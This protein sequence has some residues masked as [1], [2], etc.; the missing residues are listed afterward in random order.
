MSKSKNSKSLMSL[1]DFVQQSPTAW[2]AVDAIKQ[3]ILKQGFH[4]LNEADLWQLAY[5]QRYFTVRN[6][7]T[8]CA[9][10]MPAKRIKTCCLV[11]A[12]TDSPSFKLKPNFEYSKG[13]MT[14]LG[15]ELYGSPLLSSWLNRDLGIAGR[16]TYLDKRGLLQESLVRIEDAPMV[17][18]QLAIHLDRTANDTGLV[19][20]KQEHLSALAAVNYQAAGSYLEQ[21]LLDRC[22]SAKQLL[23]HDLFLYPLEGPRFVGPNQQLLSG[24]RLDNLCSVFAGLEALLSLPE[25]PSSDNLAMA[26]FWDNEEIGSVSAQGAASPFLPHL[27]ERISLSMG[28]TREDYLCLLCNALCISVDVA[29]AWHPNYPD[30]H[31]ARHQPQLNGGIVL[32]FN[33]QQRYASD[34]RSASR[35]AAACHKL[36]LPLQNFASRNDIPSGSTIGPITAALTGMPTVDIG[37]PQLS[38]HSSRELIGCQDQQQMTQLLKELLEGIQ[39]LRHGQSPN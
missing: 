29:H 23:V 30:K 35:V 39:V 25:N 2:H 4:E 11:A 3:L 17:I 22:P 21:L 20:N 7:S 18:P 9:F 1:L 24:Y 16:I 36:K 26:V 12:H 19:L 31:D 38:M 14:M 5:G 13:N 34:S 6:G 8:L 37:I 15:V 10:V 28:G 27:L 32:K 33:A